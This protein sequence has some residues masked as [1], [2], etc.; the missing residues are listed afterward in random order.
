MSADAAAA[1]GVDVDLLALDEALKELAQLDPRKAKIVE[2]RFFGGLSYAESA[3]Q[4]GIS[5]K[6][7][8]SDWYF[9]RAWLRD[10]L[11]EEP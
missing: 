1:P 7:A 9:A 2:L 10:R 3:C 11:S 4:L 5:P 8:E 6:T